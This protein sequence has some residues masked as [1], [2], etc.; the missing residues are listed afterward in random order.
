MEE[1]SDIPLFVIDWECAQLGLP[2]IDIGQMMAEM[3]ALS[4]YKSIEAGLW[5]LQGFV[6]AYRLTSLDFAFRACI[7]MGAHLLCITSMFP[8]W[9]SPQQVEEVITMGRDIIVHAW[10]KDRAWFE[11]GDIACIFAAI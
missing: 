7:Q 6:E 8:G 9:G 5:L 10:E 4:L 2:S 11:G 3:Y 1:G